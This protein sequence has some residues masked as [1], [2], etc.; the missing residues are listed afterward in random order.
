MIQATLTI[1]INIP[2]DNAKDVKKYL[3]EAAELLVDSIFRYEKH[4]YETTCMVANVDGMPIY[5]DESIEL[6][7]KY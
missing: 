6:P 1:K 5:E 2:N 7:E 4:S 3:E